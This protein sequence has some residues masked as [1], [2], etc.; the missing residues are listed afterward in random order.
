MKTLY[1]FEI[2]REVEKDITT[3]TAEG[4]LTKKEKVNEPIYV[5]LKKL[6]RREREEA[7]LMYSSYLSD[8]IK[9]GIVTRAMIAKIYANSGGTI[10]DPQKKKYKTLYEDYTRLQAEF[11]IASVKYG[12][13]DVSDEDKNKLAEITDKFWDI[14]SE[15]Q[16]FET[17]QAQLF[18]NTA[19]VHARNKTMLWLVVNMLYVR[20]HKEAEWVPFFKGEDLDEKLDHYDEISLLDSD[21]YR[22]KIA[23][24]GAMLVS[25]WYAGRAD[26]PE[27]FKYLD[28]AILSTNDGE[29]DS[30]DNEDDPEPATDS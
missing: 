16:R 20:D 11:Q 2:N 5:A 27:D 26:T 4:T 24:K 3:E 6:T 8:C 15:L 1:E 19:E 28:E 14:F 7:D 21:D 22:Q 18:N 10:S 23:E 12:G 25:F 17:E 9:R 30:S 29:E 13:D